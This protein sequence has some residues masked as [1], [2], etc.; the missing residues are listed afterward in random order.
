MKKT[1]LAVSL[2]TFL[3]VLVICSFGS[4]PPNKHKANKVVMKVEVTI[5]AAAAGQTPSTHSVKLTWT[6]STNPAG[7][8]YNVYK[9]TGSCPA[10]GLPTGAAK[11]ASALT[12]LTFTDAGITTSGTFC[13][14]ATAVGPGGESSASNLA[15]AVIPAPPAAPTNFTVV[16][17][18]P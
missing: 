14:Y 15:A 11:L 9:A 13:Y 7:T 10:S 1:R 18:S 4:P 3:F 16:V 12:A 8:T 2:I 6:D 5:P 17:T